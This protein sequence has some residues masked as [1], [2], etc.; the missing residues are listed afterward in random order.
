VNRL[1]RG[2]VEKVVSIKYNVT[3]TWAKPVLS[4]VGDKKAAPPEI[5]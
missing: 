4:K 3:G 1:F 2:P 5:K